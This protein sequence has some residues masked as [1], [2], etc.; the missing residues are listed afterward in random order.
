MSLLRED[1]SDKPDF[2]YIAELY[3]VFSRIVRRFQEGEVK[4]ARLNWR[5]CKDPQTYRESAIRHLL[6]D[7]SGATDEDHKSAAI[8]NLII[9]MDLEDIDKNS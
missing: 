9:L 7:I 3:P 8:A 2:T 5:E 6:Q 1:K 4:Y